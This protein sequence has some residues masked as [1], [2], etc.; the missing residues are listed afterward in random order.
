MLTTLGDL[1]DPPQDLIRLREWLLEH[2]CPIVAMESTGVY[3]RPVHN[4]IE[5]YVKVMVV[6]ARRIRTVPDGRPI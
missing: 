2:E 3:W 5:G 6:N 4:I 1:Q